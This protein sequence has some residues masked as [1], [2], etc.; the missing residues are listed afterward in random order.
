MGG[1]KRPHRLHQE[2]ESTKVPMHRTMAN[3]IRFLGEFLSRPLA[4][5]GVVP[6]SFFLAKTIVAGLDLRKAEAV[7]EYGPGTGIFTEYIL[8]GIGP[9]AQFLAIEINPHLAEIFEARYPGVVLVQDSVANVKAICDRAGITAVDCIISGLPWASFSLSTQKEL[10][11]AMMQVLKPGGRL[12]TFAYLH[13]LLLP[14]GKRF[15][16]LLPQYFRS[17]SKSRVVW[18]NVPPAFVYRCER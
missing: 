18:L 14:A 7:L 4:T 15:A 17:V 5:G 13:G 10:L 8:R 6:S 1:G 16:G 2:S 11:D 9:T 3:S 12:V